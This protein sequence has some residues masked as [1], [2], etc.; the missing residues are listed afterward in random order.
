MSTG[1]HKAV[2]VSMADVRPNLKPDVVHLLLLLLQALLQ[3]AQVPGVIGG[4]LGYRA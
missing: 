3:V 1:S 4:W 2:G